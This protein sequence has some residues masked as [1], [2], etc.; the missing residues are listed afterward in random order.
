M[1]DEFDERRNKNIIY[2]LIYKNKKKRYDKEI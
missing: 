1:R 2:N